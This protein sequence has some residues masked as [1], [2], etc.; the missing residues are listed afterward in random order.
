MNAQERDCQE[1]FCANLVTIERRIRC[2]IWSAGIRRDFEDVVQEALIVALR[3]WNRAYFKGRAPEAFAHTIGREAA[4][5]ALRA[6]YAAQKHRAAS[7]KTGKRATAKRSAAPAGRSC[8]SAVW[9]E[10]AFR[11]DW[12]AFVASLPE[13]QQEAV[14][15]FSAGYTLSQVCQKLRINRF[16]LMCQRRRWRKRWY[17]LTT[18]PQA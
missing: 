17:A 9:K 2:R 14:R 18:L 8:R 5:H 11:I 15:L 3:E 1:R 6:L 4:W 12:P 16:T 10:A 13:R 7:L